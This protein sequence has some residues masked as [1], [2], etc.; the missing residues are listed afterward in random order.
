[1]WNSLP[2]E[3]R[4]P[5]I[6]DFL[7]TP[8]ELNWNL[9]FSQ[10]I[11]SFFVFHSCTLLFR[12]FFAV[13]ANVMFIRWMPSPVAWQFCSRGPPDPWG[14]QD[15]RKPAAGKSRGPGKTQG[16]LGPPRTLRACTCHVWIELN[17]RKNDYFEN[18]W[19][20]MTS[21]NS[22]T[23]NFRRWRNSMLYGLI[24]GI[25]VMITM[26]YFMFTMNMSGCPMMQC[27]DAYNNTIECNHTEECHHKMHGM[28][29]L[30]GLSLKNLL[31]FV[32]SS[33]CQ[34]IFHPMILV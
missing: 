19:C 12:F 14:G 27:F 18:K 30:P 2:A 17:Q 20:Q 33:P 34:V 26:M 24:F 28:M 15:G 22:R 31:L 13:Y 29:L 1:M 32:L 8:S 5:L 3:L 11:D 23:L 9:T 7:S 25:P 10:L 4:D 16:G 6:P 21:L